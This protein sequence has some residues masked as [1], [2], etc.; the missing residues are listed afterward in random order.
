[1][2]ERHLPDL[3][4]EW[5]EE[6]TEF[7][8]VTDF[9]ESLERRLGQQKLNASWEAYR[10]GLLNALIEEIELEVPDAIVRAEMD[11]LLHNFVN[12][13]EQQDI[14]LAD[15]FEATGLSQDQMLSHHDI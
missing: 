10:T 13:L 2:R 5:V 3:T 14:T 7:D 12:R 4:D 11:Q 15:Y 9:E 1:M 6:T 8:T